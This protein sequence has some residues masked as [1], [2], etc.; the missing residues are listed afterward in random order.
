LRSIHYTYNAFDTLC[1]ERD[2]VSLFKAEFFK[3]VCMLFI[4]FLSYLY[5]YSL[6]RNKY[7]R[8]RSLGREIEIG[9]IFA[10][11]RKATKNSISVTLGGE[12]GRRRIDYP[13]RL[14]ANETT[15]R[16]EA[17]SKINYASNLD[18]KRKLTSFSWNFFLFFGN[19][20][21]GTT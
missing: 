5:Y 12:N 3:C 21:L 2:F 19:E 7:C 1:K 17:W 11:T 16:R 6:I 9:T 20:T 8:F 18:R 4:S 10:R 13:V 15:S 14:C